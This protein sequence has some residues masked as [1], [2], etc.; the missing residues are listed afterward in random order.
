MK[1]LSK[2]IL[3]A[4]VIL[5]ITQTTFAIDLDTARSK[6]L[7]KEQD[8][9]LLGTTDK[10][11]DQAKA[12]IKDVNAKRESFYQDIAKKTGAPIDKV[13]ADAA[14]KIRDEKLGH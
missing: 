1:S 8:D 9:G 6:G 3:S 10:S 2:F 11:D 13:K 14:K 7:V 5:G 12:L 4:V